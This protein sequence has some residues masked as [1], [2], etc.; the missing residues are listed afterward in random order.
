MSSLRTPA[1]RAVNRVAKAERKLAK[2]EARVVKAEAK[3]ESKKA[4]LEAAKRI[5][6][7]ALAE[8]EKLGDS[9]GSGSTGTAET[10]S[11]ANA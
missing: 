10:P 6:E 8:A 4:K 7:A 9:S 11:A 3:L 5:Y 1:N 2:A